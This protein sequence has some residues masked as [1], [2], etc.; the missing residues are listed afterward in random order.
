MLVGISFECSGATCGS[1]A[2]PTISAV[3]FAGNA[4]TRVGGAFANG[5]DTQ[6]D[7]WRLFNPPA[8]LTGNVTVTLSAATPVV[9]G[10]I[11]FAGVDQSQ[12][13]TFTG[14]N[15]NG[16]TLQV[17]SIPS[18]AG[19]L[20]FSTVSWDGTLTVANI[21]ASGTTQWRVRTDANDGANAGQTGAASTKDG[22]KRL[23]N[24]DG[25]TEYRRL[26]DRR[27]LHRAGLHDRHSQHGLHADADP[28]PAISL[29]R[30]AARSR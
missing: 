14:T 9:A 7:I 27:R 16:G 2:T 15:G 6:V 11:T 17:T 28:W 19:E 8:N 13:L 29:C 3:N 10:A 18:A 1:S 12:S 25:N 20:I 4:L 24:H 5:N 22:G 26:G 23:G 21:S 30:L